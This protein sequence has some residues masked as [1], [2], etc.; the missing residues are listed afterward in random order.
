MTDFFFVCGLWGET[1]SWQLSKTMYGISLKDEVVLIDWA[2][3]VKKRKEWG[4]S[5]LAIQA[6]WIHAWVS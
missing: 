3:G 6:L 4:A 2:W 1:I 5:N